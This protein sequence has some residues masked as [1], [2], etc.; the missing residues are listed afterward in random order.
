MDGGVHSASV[1]DPNSIPRREST[2]PMS[3]AASYYPSDRHPYYVSSQPL[4]AWTT[5]APAQP[6]I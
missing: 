2:N 6:Q 3:S 5:A 4:S 1:F